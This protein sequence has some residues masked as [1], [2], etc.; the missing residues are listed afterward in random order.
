MRQKLH[1]KV[2]MFFP[3][4]MDFECNRGTENFCTSVADPESDRDPYVF[5]PPGSISTRCN[6]GSGSGSFYRQAKIFLIFDA[7]VVSKS[8][9]QKKTRKKK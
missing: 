1:A 9:K 7:N 6:S 4:I 5:G 2:R 3:I 8:K